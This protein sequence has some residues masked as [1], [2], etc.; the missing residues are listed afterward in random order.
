MG[1]HCVIDVELTIGSTD[2]SQ[3]EKYAY[4]LTGQVRDGFAG[5]ELIW[6]D[7]HCQASGV[8]KSV[9]VPCVSELAEPTDPNMTDNLE[10]QKPR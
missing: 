7:Q 3:H 8:M 6:E 9:G 10:L 5:V 4:S 2:I 1:Y